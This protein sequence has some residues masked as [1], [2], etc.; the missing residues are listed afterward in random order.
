VQESHSQRTNLRARV[1]SGFATGWLERG[2]PK[3]QGA[4][5]LPALPSREKYWME[6]RALALV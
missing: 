5:L 2:P 3:V 4:F 1:S 6:R